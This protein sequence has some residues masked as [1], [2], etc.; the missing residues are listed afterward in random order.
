[1]PS[2]NLSRSAYTSQSAHSQVER[3][4][5]NRVAHVKLHVS[6]PGPSQILHIPKQVCP[7]FSITFRSIFTN[8]EPPWPDLRPEQLHS[9]SRWSLH[10]RSLGFPRLVAL[11][12]AF[13]LRY[14]TAR[15][16]VRHWLPPLVCRRSKLSKGFGS[17]H[18]DAVADPLS[19]K[20]NSIAACSA[21]PNSIDRSSPGVGPL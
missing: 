18:P 8:K 7:T 21:L 19:V 17:R 10:D 14:D 13:K 2:D 16:R 6:P 20:L 12:P 1:M 15:L 9:Q 3:I 4:I 5:T 11:S